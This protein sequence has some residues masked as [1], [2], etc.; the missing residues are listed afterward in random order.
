M[1]LMD[2]ISLIKELEV[3]WEKLSAELVDFFNACFPNNSLQSQ[4]FWLSRYSENQ[5][6]FAVVF[7]NLCHFLWTLPVELRR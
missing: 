7:I 6:A 1:F 2:I 4:L 5:L 3:I